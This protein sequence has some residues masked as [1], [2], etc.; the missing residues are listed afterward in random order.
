MKKVSL[1]ILCFERDRAS[2]IA[3][4]LTVIMF[5]LSLFMTTGKIE[6]AQTLA[7]A[8]IALLGMAVPAFAAIAVWFSIN[9]MEH[10]AFARP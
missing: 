5:I 3:K 6:G 7:V 1:D 10:K 8:E 9:R 2:S 4:A